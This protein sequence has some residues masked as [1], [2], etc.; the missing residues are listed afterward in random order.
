MKE[1]N[2]NE[3]Y[4]EY[5]FSMHGFEWKL[6]KQ[7]MSKTVYELSKDGLTY[8]WELPFGVTDMKSYMEL[9]CKQN[10]FMRLKIERLKGTMK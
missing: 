10:H 9:A 5:W 8:K 1:K 2:R 3:R 7:Y 4:A 6:V